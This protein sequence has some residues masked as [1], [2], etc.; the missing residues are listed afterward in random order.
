LEILPKPKKRYDVDGTSDSL[1][2]GL[3]D[4]VVINILKL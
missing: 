3:D 4:T 1:E 2:G